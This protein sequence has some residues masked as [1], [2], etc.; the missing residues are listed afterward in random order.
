M[1]TNER[2]YA[3]IFV[4][5]WRQIM[6]ALIGLIAIAFIVLIVIQQALRSAD[7]NTPSYDDYMDTV[8]EKCYRDVLGKWYNFTGGIG[9][10]NGKKLSPSNP[11]EWERYIA[12]LRH[13]WIVWKHDPN[14]SYNLSNP[15]I[16]DQSMG[17][18]KVVRSILGD[19]K[20]GFFVECGAFDGETRSNTLILERELGW[21]GLLV[22][23]DP[24]NFA[25]M[26]TK[27]RRAYLTPTC[28]SVG[29]YPT[30][31]S[32]LMARNVGRLHEPNDTDAH[33]ENS[34]DVAHSGVH[35]QVQCFPFAHY[36]AALNVTSVDYFS[37]DIEG[38]ELQVLKTIPF[39]G[40]DIKTLSVEFSHVEDGKKELIN[41]MESKGYYV[42]T[43]VVRE[44]RLAHDII[45]AKRVDEERTLI[46]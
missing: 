3:R 29:Q 38:Y 46:R 11:V 35:I 13:E 24:I 4:P 40:I 5:F 8:S 14:L 7:L 21:S 27:N 31:S 23:A 1:C 20:N 37:L 17:Q 2:S 39:D 28:L 43:F 42:Y 30:V 19:K 44:D 26:L 15:E 6:Y 9:W 41:F 45:F 22:E 36:M 18:A 34:D 33:L 32:F 25:K 10:Y 16:K 12:K